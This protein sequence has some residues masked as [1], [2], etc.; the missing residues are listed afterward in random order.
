VVLETLPEDVRLCEATAEEKVEEAEQIC[1]GDRGTIDRYKALVA[2]VELLTKAGEQKQAAISKLQVCVEI[3]IDITV[4]FR[5]LVSEPKER[6]N[7]QCV[8]SH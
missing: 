4:M 7:S 5:F 1:L 3:I 6:M 8:C 2:D